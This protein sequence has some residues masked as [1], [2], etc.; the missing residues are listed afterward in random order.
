M[1]IR[2]LGTALLAALAAAC[3]P[4]TVP[5]L[6]GFQIY[7]VISGSM[8]PAIP[9]GSLAYIRN[10]S[11]ADVQTDDVIAFYAA[12]DS[13]SVIMH[14]VVENRTVMGAFI[15]KGDANQTEDRNP[16]PYE[17]LIGE[18]ACSIPWAGV[19]A[20]VLTSRLGKYAAVGV[21]VA[22][23]LLHM[24]ASLLERKRERV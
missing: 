24:L 23:V 11:P 16:I 13:A 3:F 7:S 15:T 2:I 14:R 1:C 22:A 19:A 6:F 18:V 10:V 4:L 5:K 8:A 12:Q 20:S 9:T 21:I 17:H